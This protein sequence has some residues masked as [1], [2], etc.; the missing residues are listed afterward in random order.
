[1]TETIVSFLDDYFSKELVI[2]LIS[3]LP[4]LELQGGMVA[5]ALLGIPWGKAMVIC[6]IGSVLPIPFIL[7]FIKRVLH[8]MITRGVFKKFALR[9][10][11]IG[12]SK[13]G[14]FV[15]KYPNKML[16]GLFIFVA[17]PLPGSGAWTSALIAALLDLP[18]KKTVPIIGI[19]IIT[20]GIIMCIITYVIPSFIG[21]K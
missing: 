7:L 3:V 9:V 16:L 17:S 8:F 12:D 2:F 13:V 18:T 5:A 1:M 19:G 14:E 11:N 15:R 6:I 21:I 20:T 10:H 4:V